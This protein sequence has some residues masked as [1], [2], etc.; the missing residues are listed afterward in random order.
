[1]L[2]TS[3]EFLGFLLLLFPLYYLCPARHQWKLLLAGSILFYFSAGPSCLLYMLGVTAAVYLAAVRIG[4]LA[5]EQEELLKAGGAE[6]DRE[7][8]RACKAAYRKRQKRVLLA[9]LLLSLGI[10]AAAK[11][12]NF[13]IGNINSLVRAFGGQRQLGFWD[14][15]L[16]M[17]ISF[18]TFQAIGYLIDVYRGVVPPER[19]FFK[20]ALFVSFF[21]QLVQGPIS[22]FRALS[23]GLYAG[24]RF[25]A[26][27]FS[28]GL[29]RMLWG[30]F[31]KL[32]LADRMLVAV[33]AIVRDSG[34]YTGA[35]VLAGMLFYALE[36]Y[37]DFTGGIDITIGVSEALGIRVRENFLRPY[38]SKSIKEYW[39]RWH[40][41]MGAWFTDYVFYPVSV[42]RPMLRLSR[43]ARSHLG[44]ALGRRLPVYLSSFAVW[45]AT[46]VWHGASWNFVAWGLANW[47]VLMASQ[48]LEPLY[49]RFHRRFAVRERSWFKGFQVVRTVLLMSALRLFDC[50]RDVPATFRMF[51]SLLTARNWAVLLDGSLLNLGLSPLDFGILAAGLALLLAVSLIQRR[52]SVRDRI[53]AWPYPLRALLWFGLFLVVLFMGFYGI[54]YDKSQ[55][56]Y[57]QF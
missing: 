46:G 25:D 50:Y 1:M 21:P 9:A 31:K 10:L 44:Q 24:H 15:A 37:A 20:F 41:S 2:F 14:L 29:Q 18:Y 33:N 57:N 52:G 5:R 4:D 6:T 35:Y 38:F 49:R 11:Y 8:R 28:R 17:G 55:F 19:N 3:Y 47:A 16:P 26:A 48:E 51:G 53:A 13:L 30:F 45:L 39:R 22:R 54:G 43:F 34:R 27:V 40:I 23:Q 32:V 7:A 42:S 36:L 56:I 12:V